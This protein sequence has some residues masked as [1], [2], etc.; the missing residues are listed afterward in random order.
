M[1]VNYASGWRAYGH[2]HSEAKILGMDHQ[3]RGLVS[4]SVTEA[5][6][7]RLALQVGVIVTPQVWLKRIEVTTYAT[8]GAPSFSENPLLRIP[9]LSV[10]AGEQS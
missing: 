9:Q 8:K 4:R 10:F 1:I 7:E 6:R 2:S 5:Q 3:S